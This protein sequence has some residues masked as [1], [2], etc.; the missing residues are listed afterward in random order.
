MSF[1][2]RLLQ[3]P[4]SRSFFLFGARNTGKSTLLRH[5]FSEKEALWIDFLNPD[6]EERYAREPIRL[7]QEVLALEDDIKYN[8]LDGGVA[9]VFYN[10]P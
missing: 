10:Q 3:L 2:Q 9:Q 4:I 6:E 5:T 7:K 8:T 1:V